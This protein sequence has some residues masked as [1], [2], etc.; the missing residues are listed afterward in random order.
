MLSSSR[1]FRE[2]LFEHRLWLQSLGDHARFIYNAFTPA[3]VN[4]ARTPKG[5]ISAFDQ[6]LQRARTIATQ[7]ELARRTRDASQQTKK[8]RFQVITVKQKTYPKH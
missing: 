5:F 7:T 8:L 1:L 2:A 3:Q 4:L 6:L